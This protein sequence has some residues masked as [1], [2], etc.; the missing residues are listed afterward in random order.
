[1]V[2][3]AVAGK[4]ITP[5]GVAVVAASVTLDGPDD[6]VRHSYG[7]R[8]DGAGRFDFGGVP[9]G[10][11]KLEV[12]RDGT[13]GDA[14]ARLD[15]SSDGGALEVVVPAVATI[16]GRVVLGGKPVG[17]LAAAAAAGAPALPRTRDAP[18]GRFEIDNAPVGTVA[19]V[20]GG[21]QFRGVQLDG[22][23]TT[24][25]HVTDL[26]DITVGSGGVV[27]G[28]VVDRGGAPVAGALVTVDRT[29]NVPNDNTAL[30]NPDD[31]TRTAR[32]DAGGRF[33]VIGLP[34][35]AGLLI[36]AGAAGRGLSAPRALVADDLAHEV[37]LVLA[38]VGTVAGTIAHDAGSHVVRVTQNGHARGYE[39]VA[40]AGVFAIDQI[41]PGDYLATVDDLVMAPIAFHVDAARVT[42]VTIPLAPVIVS[43]EVVGGA[44]P[45]SG[46]AV[47]VPDG[48]ALLASTSQ[49]ATTT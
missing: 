22:I 31:D 35:P 41:A 9:P 2:E 40:D 33:E 13:S 23:V 24:A 29:G 37:T 28:Q 15:V 48:S 3:A 17:M 14:V 36:R 5:D 18:D 43:V 7:A 44:A 30:L 21:P 6:S 46:A 25:G 47:W 39:S 45:C 32:T 1:M 49:S 20:I 34:D 27:R 8:V 10:D 38:G 11:Y 42:A 26:G 4:L 16:R 12:R 19:V